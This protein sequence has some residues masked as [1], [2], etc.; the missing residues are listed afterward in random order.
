MKLFKQLLPAIATYILIVL[1]FTIATG[2][3]KNNNEFKVRHSDAV[4]QT[5]DAE[6]RY[7]A[8]SPEIYHVDISP[9]LTW[10]LSKGFTKTGR[11]IGV[12]LLV[13][14]AGLFIVRGLDLVEFPGATFNYAI[15]I[16]MV[17]AAACLYGAYS[18]AYA[19][20]FV[21]VSA[22]TFSKYK[23]SLQELFTNRALIR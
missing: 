19:N 3:I 21:E 12:I 11:T 1:F 14:L 5:V 22:E 16:V 8:G 23:D 13:V 15:W 17:A 20:N 2:H 9:A 18:S 7:V 6:G 4:A 10:K